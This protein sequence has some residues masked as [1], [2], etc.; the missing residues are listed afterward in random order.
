[1]NILEDIKS[2][3][4]SAYEV[5]IEGE[6]IYSDFEYAEIFVDHTVISNFIDNIPTETIDKWKKKLGKKVLRDVLTNSPDDYMIGMAGNLTWKDAD[7][8]DWMEN[9]FSDKIVKAYKKANDIKEPIMLSIVDTELEHFL[10][11]TL[12][13]EN[14][15]VEQAYID[16]QTDLFMNRYPSVDAEELIESQLRT[17]LEAQKAHK[18]KFN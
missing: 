17:I 4:D 15:S 11:V 13:E 18:V 12:A 6:G 3:V 5:V 2:M 7:V 1:M 9:F 10:T 14:V 8:K 16:E